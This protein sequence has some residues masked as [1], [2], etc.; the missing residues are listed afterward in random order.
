MICMSM[1]S[2]MVVLNMQNLDEFSNFQKFKYLLAFVFVFNGHVIKC[3]V[4]G[5]VFLGKTDGPFTLRI[6]RICTREIWGLECTNGIAENTS[7][8]WNK[9]DFTLVQ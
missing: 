5:R 8:D 3:D 4:N 1:P 6:C 7:T 2:V 9:K